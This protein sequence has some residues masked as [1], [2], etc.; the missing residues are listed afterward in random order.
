MSGSWDC[1]SRFFLSIRQEGF[2]SSP[3]MISRRRGRR[4]C[5]R[6][7]G[8]CRRWQSY[9]NL[10]C[11]RLK[12]RREERYYAVKIFGLFIPAVA[13]LVSTISL[14]CLTMDP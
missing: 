14:L 5:T 1:L 11:E 13:F 2:I 8:T 4:N 3:G 10:D 9:R 7:P 12:M 6:L